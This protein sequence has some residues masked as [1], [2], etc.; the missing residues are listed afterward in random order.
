MT[1]Q[2]KY[3]IDYQG[4]TLAKHHFSFDVSDDLFTMYEESEVKKGA[5]KVEI[6]LAR[7]S[8]MMELEVQIVGTVEVE[9]DRCLEQLTIPIDYFGDLI[10]KITD[11][12][13][14][15]DGDI[16]WVHPTDDKLS[17]A[18]Y[19]YESVVLS[20]PYQRVHQTLAEC[21]PEM[22]KHFQIIDHDI[23]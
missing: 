1:P 8:S 15:D 6:E 21:N 5:L 19:I 7:H 11:Q 10:V 22:V 3:S 2:Q 20:L 16:M 23:E 14:E 9:C 18:Q 13:G 12:C 4:L 17:L